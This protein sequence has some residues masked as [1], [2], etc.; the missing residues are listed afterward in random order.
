[1]AANPENF[2]ADPELNFPVFKG[3]LPETGWLS[4]DDYLEFV[5]LCLTMTNMD[6]TPVAARNSMQPEKKQFLL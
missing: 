6:G 3:D 4:M 5:L 2:D 1:M